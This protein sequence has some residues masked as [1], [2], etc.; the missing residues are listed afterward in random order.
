M[1]TALKHSFLI[2]VPYWSIVSTAGAIKGI[3]SAI[4]TAILL[5]PVT[6]IAIA[7]GCNLWGEDGLTNQVIEGSLGQSGYPII[8]RA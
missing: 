4:I 8:E 2:A 6:A 1:T 3:F 7:I 5:I